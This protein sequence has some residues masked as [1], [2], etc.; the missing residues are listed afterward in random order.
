MARPAQV[1]EVVR[2]CRV[3][4]D[5]RL[6]VIVLDPEAVAAADAFDS[7]EVGRLAELEG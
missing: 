7:V 4:R 6:D 1:V 5:V 3:T 2:R